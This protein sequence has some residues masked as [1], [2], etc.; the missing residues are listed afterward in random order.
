M[1]IIK[2]KEFSEL[3]SERM[4][5]LEKLFN[6]GFARELCPRTFS[7]KNFT[8]YWELVLQLPW[9]ALWLMLDEE[10][11]VI[12]VIGGVTYPDIVTADL[13]GVEVCWR[14][15]NEQKGKG[16]GWE[17]FF[18]FLKWAIEQ[19]A[20][21]IVTHKGLAKNSRS[22]EMFDEKI[23]EVGFSPRGCDYYFDVKE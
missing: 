17:L 7:W 19:G 4:A 8:N 6:E 12:G 10:G 13:I 15:A 18:T 5:A 1:E 11:E 23:R 22:D 20:T 16:L 3:T 21:R 9:S 14:M 2:I